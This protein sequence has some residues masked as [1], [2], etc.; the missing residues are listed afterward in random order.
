MGL[1][2]KKNTV[3]IIDDDIKFIKEISE[4]I[5]EHDNRI[6]ADFAVNGIEGIKAIKSEKYDAV[7]LD[8]YMPILDGRGFLRRLERLD[9]NKRPV[10]IA[11]SEPKLIFMGDTLA[12]YRLDYLIVKPQPYNEICN[13]I[14]DLI[15]ISDSN[16][17][18]DDTCTDDISIERS[19]S[20][21][22]KELG[23]PIHIAG[24][25]Y[26]KR[27][28]DL[29][30]KD[31]SVLH[32]ITKRLYPLLATEYSASASNIESAIRHAVDLAWKN[33][34]EHILYKLFKRTAQDGK[35]K[36]PTNS[37]LLNALSNELRIYNLNADGTCL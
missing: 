21:Y 36:R 22:M 6:E 2:M 13:T 14:E 8:L 30:A 37:E 32:S 25:R 28:L 18:I 19:I 29:A 1:I 9:C 4:Y 11:M 34:E 35:A 33:G 7:L 31:E 15:A 20:T 17:I 16:N 5:T 10:I 26:I 24:Y 12:K 27:A 3:L 23:I